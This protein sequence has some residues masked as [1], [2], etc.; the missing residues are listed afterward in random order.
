MADAAKARSEVENE[1]MVS[2]GIR[3]IHRQGGRLL[4][5]EEIE[6]FNK[7]RI[8]SLIGQ[9]PKRTPEEQSKYEAELLKESAQF[10]LM[11]MGTQYSGFQKEKAQKP[12]RSKLVNTKRR[13]KTVY[14]FIADLVT[15]T[16]GETAKELWPLLREKLAGVGSFVKETK[17]KGQSAYVYQRNPD[18]RK[19]RLT[20][21]TFE[22]NLSK[23]RSSR[24]SR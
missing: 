23:V 9:P 21:R 5:D 15:S 4:S 22:N 13:I 17:V 18:S 7:A 10:G 24:K 12:R 1:V 8:S 19:K 11:A 2:R 20:F 14:D 6:E 3:S 16:E